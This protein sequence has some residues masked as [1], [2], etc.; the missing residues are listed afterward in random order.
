MLCVS[1]VVT[2]VCYIT[3]K[4]KICEDNLLSH[5]SLVRVELSNKS[6]FKSCGAV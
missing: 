2:A 5:I 3:L 1:V 6:V 4:F